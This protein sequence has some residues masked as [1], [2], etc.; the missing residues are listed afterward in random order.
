MFQRKGVSL[1]SENVFH[2]EHFFISLTLFRG[3]KGSLTKLFVSLRPNYML[4]KLNYNCN[5]DKEKKV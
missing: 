4:K 3:G 5:N 1:H 2:K